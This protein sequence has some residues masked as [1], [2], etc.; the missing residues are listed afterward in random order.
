MIATASR[1]TFPFGTRTGAASNRSVAAV[2]H[3]RRV[4]RQVVPLDQANQQAQVGKALLDAQ[5]TA[6][7]LGRR[8]FAASCSELARRGHR[9]INETARKRTWAGVLFMDDAEFVT[10]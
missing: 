7:R 9:P 1:I 5:L 3:R 10:L 2:G 8:R 4:I 6:E